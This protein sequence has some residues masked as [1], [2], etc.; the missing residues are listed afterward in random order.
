MAG[1]DAHAYALI[2]MALSRNEASM[3]SYDADATL[4][5][6]NKPGER[7]AVYRA[8]LGRCIREA[9]GLSGQ[10][11]PPMGIEV[12]TAEHLYS[13]AEIQQ[14]A[15]RPDFIAHQLSHTGSRASAPRFLDRRRDE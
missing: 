9:L 13:L 14:I 3:S 2:A 5:T 11:S 10:P 8:A 12:Q 15:R 4:Y 1:D 6:W 7:H